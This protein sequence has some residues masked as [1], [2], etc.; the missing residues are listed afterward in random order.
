MDNSLGQKGKINLSGA[1]GIASAWFG[2]HCGAGFATGA[3]G[4]VYYT[5]YGAWAFI[6]P[7]IAAF[8]MSF[9]AYNLWNFSRVFETYTYRE[10]YNKLFEP[11][12]HVFATIQE[13]CYFIILIMAMG[14]VLSGAASLFEKLFGVNYVLGSFLISMIIFVFTVFGSELLFKVSSIL[15]TVL[16][17]SLIVVNAAGIMVSGPQI[18]NIFATWETEV[19]FWKALVPAI[20]YAMFQSTVMCGTV[21]IAS[22]LKTEKD[23]KVASVFGFILN[24]GIMALV[25]IMMLGYYPGVVGQPLPVLGIIQD[26]NSPILLVAYNISLAVAFITTG[27]SLVFSLIARFEIF[28][29]NIVPKIETRRKLLAII[30]ITLC[31]VISLAGL[32]NII[33][34]GYSFV[35]YISIPFV[36][37]PTIIMVPMKIKKKLS[38]ANLKG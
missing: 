1:F 24:G 21:S 10:T 7:L 15:S 8:L 33:G 29:Q 34:K 2:L 19:S 13:I 14:G 28:G 25:A 18:V 9:Y 22:I 32:L 26:M 11:Y 38:E 17:I 12:G 3:Q 16:I 23:T 30:V 5:Q 36:Y 4:V 37:L 6:T 27:I 35:G 20:T 31:F